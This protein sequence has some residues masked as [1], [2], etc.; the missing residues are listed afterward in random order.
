M[1]SSFHL[2]RI[3]LRLAFAVYNLSRLH[4]EHIKFGLNL[5]LVCLSIFHSIVYFSSFYTISICNWRVVYSWWAS[6]CWVSEMMLYVRIIYSW[7]VFGWIQYMTFFHFSQMR[8][9]L[10]RLLSLIYI[11]SWPYIAFCF[12]SC[13]ILALM[14]V[15]RAASYCVHL[16]LLLCLVNNNMISWWNFY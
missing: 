8:Q 3:F 5:L 1:T 4:S 16:L 11:C 9:L 6:S 15:F 7:K 13:T 12:W 10:R 2:L 14:V